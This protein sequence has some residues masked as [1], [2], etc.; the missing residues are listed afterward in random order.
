MPALDLFGRRWAL[1]ADDIP[2]L[3]FPAAV[4]HGLW[5]IFLVVAFSA[6]QK[7]SA[8]AKAPPYE[9]CIVGLFVCFFLSCVIEGWL[10]RE[11]LK[12]AHGATIPLRFRLDAS[13]LLSWSRS[14]LSPSS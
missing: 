7:P 14:C 5:F 6:I 10:V 2:V 11:G 4:F 3:A 1:A 12:G 13:R 9:A 8:C